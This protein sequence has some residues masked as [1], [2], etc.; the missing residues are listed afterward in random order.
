MSFVPAPAAAH[1]VRGMADTRNSLGKHLGITEQ[2]HVMPF[3]RY[4]TLA[5]HV[6]QAL[7]TQKYA[8]AQV[9]VLLMI[10]GR[11]QTGSVDIHLTD[12]EDIAMPSAPA[13]HPARTRSPTPSA[14]W[15]V[16]ALLTG[17]RSV[18]T[19]MPASARS[20]CITRRHACAPPGHRARSVNIGMRH[21]WAPRRYQRSELA[22]S[23]V[24]IRAGHDKYSKFLSGTWPFR[25]QAQRT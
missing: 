11:Q 10:V 1:T 3:A 15:T 23:P 4:R 5:E 12:W 18:H 25:S 6:G 21:F 19:K 2:D 16:S 13:S 17:A 22:S 24:R 14:S 20:G 7:T 8:A 9:Y